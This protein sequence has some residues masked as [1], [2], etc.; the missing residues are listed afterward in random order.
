LSAQALAASQSCLT[1]Y[2]LKARYAKGT[3]GRTIKRAKQFFQ[4]AVDRELIGKSPFAKIKAPGQA[5]EARKFFVTREAAYK[6]LE[7][8]PD[9]EWRLLFALSRFGGLRCPSEHLALA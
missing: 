9:A 5:N 1:P 7:A 6:V 2:S 3:I 8:C 4:A